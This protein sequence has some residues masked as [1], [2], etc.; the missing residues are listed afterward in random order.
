MRPPFIQRCLKT[1]FFSFKANIQKTEFYFRALDQQYR[2]PEMEYPS[3][4]IEK[5]NF[6]DSQ[7]KQIRTEDKESFESK[8]L[9][10]KQHCV[11]VAVAVEVS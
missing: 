7:G 10:Q 4:E 2:T 9:K 1:M 6:R 3:R 5:N 8:V 11:A